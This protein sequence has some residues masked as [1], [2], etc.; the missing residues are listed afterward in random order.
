MQADDDLIDA[1]CGVGSFGLIAAD[2]V[3][4]V[5]G[6]DSERTTIEDTRCNTKKNK[7]EN[8]NFY[9]DNADQVMNR[10]AKNNENASV[11]AATAPKKGLLKGFIEASVKM[12]Q[13]SLSISHLTQTLWY[14]ILSSLSKMVMKL[15]QSHRLML[16]LKH[17]I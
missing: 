5:R 17:Q 1:Y 11:I 13:E 12:Q 15:R 3:K 9:I 7:V 2:K 14:V 4:S 10:L 8:A 16:H 6:V